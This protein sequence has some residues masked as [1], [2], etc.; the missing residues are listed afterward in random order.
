MARK[1]VPHDGNSAV[2]HVAHATNEVIA[3][4]PITPSSPM[5]EISDAKSAAG[6]KNIWGTIPKVAELQSEG[7]AAGAVHG[8]LSTGA[9]TT[10]FTASQ[11][12]LLMIPNM[13]KIAGELTPTVFH[14]AARSLA[15]QALSIFGDH[16]DV[17]ACRQ[18]GWAML[19]STNVQE[20]MDF[21]LISQAATLESRVPFLHFFEG[22]RVS[23]ELQK[24]E[25]LTFDDMRAMLDQKAI[26]A[27]RARG[28]TPDR[29]EMRGTAQNPDVYFQGR[30][31]VN[32]YIDACPAIVQKCF[33]QFAKLTGRQ[34]QLFDY[35]GDPNAEKVIVAMGSGCEVTHDVIECLNKKGSKLGLLKVRLYRPFDVAAFAKAL[36]KTVKKIAVLD[37]TKE[38]GSLGEPLYEDVRTAVGEAMHLKLMN[39]YPV[40]VGG[41]FG[42]GSAEFTPGMVKAVYDNLD[43]G[44]PKNH[45]TVGIVDDVTG[46]SLSYDPAFTVGGDVYRAMF[47]GLGSDGTVGANKNTIKIIGDLTDNNTQGYFEYDS[48]K[49][50]AVTVSHL[51]F[52]KIPIRRPY[53]ISTADFLAC[54]NF[55]FLEKIDML[56]NLKP[57][58][59]FLLTSQHDKDTVWQYIPP[60][61]QKQIIDKKI[62][63]YVIDAI[64]IAEEIGLGARINTIMQVAFFKI[65]KVIDDKLA[66]GAIKDAI[67]K[68]YG[69]KGEQV[70]DMNNKAVDRAQS[71]IFEVKVPAAVQGKVEEIKV[72][73]NDAPK[74]VKE[75]TA[76]IMKRE[77]TELKVS[78][79][80]EDGTWPTATTQY[81]KRNIAV[82]IPAW[83]KDT[84]IQCG[85]CSLVCPHAAI[86]TKAYDPK[87]LK[88]APKTFKSCDV[89]DVKMPGMKYTIQVAPE[90][91]TGC[92]TCV[93]NCPAKAKEAIK[94]VPQEPLREAERENFSY[95]LSI[96]DTDPKLFD[97]NT[98]KGSQFVRPLFEFSGACAGCGETAY[99]KLLTQLFG[100]RAIIANA[101][102]CSSIYGGNLPT[103][104]Y[105]KRAD[106]R[107]PAWS[108]S[109][110]E[111]NAEFAY[112][113][114]LTVDK[115]NEYAK[116]LAQGIVSSAGCGKELVGILQE[117]LNAS[118]TTQAEIEAQRERVAKVKPLLAGC[119]CTS[120]QELAKI[121]DYFVK[122]SVWA[123]GGDGW[124]YDIG[125]GGLD[126]I[127]ATGANVK[128]LVLDTEVYS[129]T[130]GQASKS[131]PK[132]A[133]A[134]FAAG[135]KT[136][137][138]KDMALI[139]MSYGY[140]YVAKVAMGADQN[141]VVKAFVEAEA[142]DGPAIILAYASCIAHGIDMTKGLDEQK[143]AVISGHYPIMRFNPALKA[144]GKNPLSLDCKEPSITLA[145]YEGT[146]NRFN[147]LKKINPA[148]AQQ[149]V[150][151][152]QKEAKCRY[153]LYKQL[154]GV[155]CA[156]EVP[157]V[158][159][160]T[161]ENA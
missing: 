55:S 11:G 17:M 127:L 101:T 49:A 160:Q 61:V 98:V 139:A 159:V 92:G 88:D 58:G 12:L 157:G 120:C 130:G 25:E 100:D 81:E 50:G 112:G 71:E 54:H 2:A 121:A 39:A 93:F 72:V 73:P 48:K 86:R 46:T 26:D 147:Q 28:L 78:Q 137:P 14:I 60:M 124:A 75:V 87:Y 56:K 131:T 84:C 70:V 106:G 52:G 30:E 83:N 95:F 44:E 9:L 23:H 97:R 1:M 104:P 110:F 140:I 22:F 146:E 103:T 161:K 59:T 3:I 7:G 53:L 135:G 35:I 32:K 67:K 36:P 153:S 90:D 94:M 80:P 91:C 31:T 19:A 24:I 113:M 47:Y 96:P 111:D 79:M 15:C 8:A 65:S 150:E 16:S 126:H 155:N 109:L 136:M 4:Y 158:S 138:K 141:Q 18:I 132:G 125:Y 66:I 43:K 77:G 13:Y 64:K 148:A 82:N 42:L 129:N 142:Y 114:R 89:K 37:R 119:T 40:I 33:D 133:V 68:T 57:G 20:T 128:V 5:G 74:F 51:R 34:Y 117:I 115:M 10:T 107:G 122:K 123:V 149:L 134:Q 108:N 118:Q 6:V 143:K 152:A 156:G 116:E 154:A 38:P 99:V 29:P 105:C 102:G 63:L 145:D 62:K 45:F 41:R 151:E 76:T 144:Q 85:R 21:A 69:K 27:H